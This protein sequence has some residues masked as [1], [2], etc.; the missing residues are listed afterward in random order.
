M[1]FGTRHFLL[2]VFFFFIVPNMFGQDE[3]KSIE[4][5][6]IMVAIEAQH[7]VKFSYAENDVVGHSIFPP[8][9]KLP[10]KAKLVYLTNRTL[11]Y[12]KENE[13]Y[14]S[15]YTTLIKPKDR[16][17]CAYV[18]DEVGQPIDNA[19]IQYNGDRRL[20]TASDGF[21]EL[22][23]G[24]KD[25]VYVTHMGYEAI[26]VKPNYTPDDDCLEIILK[27]S[28]VQLQEVVTERYIATGI[29]KQ[30]DGTYAIKP[31]K[32]GI[33]PGLIEPDVLQ[34]MQQLPG[35]NSIDETV[36]NINVRGGTHDQN[37]FMWNG[38]RLF[39]TG[40][41]FGLISALSP[42]LAHDIKISKNGTSAFYGESVSSA[43]DISSRPKDIGT[44]STSIGT[45]M[46]SADFYTKIKAS[47]KANFEV[48]ARRSFTD[49]L[50]FPTYSK[51]SKRIFQNTIVT[52]LS[53]ST[54]VNYKSDKEF[55]F[56]DFTTQYHQKI[57]TKHDL[58]ADVIGISNTLDF[59]QGT[60]TATNVVT[61]ISTLNQLTLGGTVAWRTQWS[62]GHSSEASLYASYYNVDG[63]NASIEN[64]QTIEQQNRILDAG[65][66]FS[67]NLKLSPK[68]TLH[69]GYQY[70]E[71]G[72]ENND[73]V[74]QPDYS[75]NVKEV[76]RSH[77]V[78]GE[79]EYSP[80]ESRLYARGGLRI[81]YIE[82]FA[83]LYA[84]PRLLVNYQLNNSFKLEAL[85][86]R[87]SQTASQIVALQADFLGIEKRRWVLANDNDL[88]VQKSSQAS[89]G[90][91]FKSRRWLVTL[92]NFYKKVDGI[93]TFGQAFQD[94]LELTQAKGNYTV[95]G[96]EF[97]I[98]KQFHDFY[99]WLSYTW[100]NN[101]YR[102]DGVEPYK[103]PS[104]FE[105]SH[106]VNTAVIYEWDNLK[107][108]L[109]SK[110]FTGRPYTPPLI[111]TPTYNNVGTASI[112]YPYPNS[113]NIN[114]FFQV[115]FSASYTWQ[116]PR[117]ISMQVGVAVQNIF[118]R[119]NIINRYYRINNTNDGVEVVNTY[120]LERTP[121]ALIKFSF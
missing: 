51:Y 87:K 93:T 72:T 23:A 15:V 39:Q 76:L 21:F 34:A 48:S 60:I 2:T 80:A 38:I 101:N 41:F 71:I 111:N 49:V 64:N 99:A 19:V 121:N 6:K 120:S 100:N 26:I 3:L 79:M 63:K 117:K 28:P 90:A 58:Y 56:Y 108:A 78:I 94:Q 115:N 37:L 18:V 5:K 82:Q 91:T 65:L 97:L 61:Q 13:R 118:N 55:Y 16:H 84:E 110:W 50:D 9:P 17:G 86:E 59:T 29:S 54:D 114:N 8:D 68:F 1:T 92:D 36:S 57:G 85:A 75:R 32:F 88:P 102:F 20:V 83:M 107:M 46:I 95:Y 35:I 25:D 24:F 70:N 53:N 112:V 22:P 31:R 77:A 106:T 66:R 44:G 40:H 30:K 119:Q 73:R 42:N 11:L 105:L 12:F 43:V 89:V 81:N 96:T 4:L 45:N 33:L 7:N 104:S 67:D 103:F 69:S 74:N 109:G 27:L 47:E 98:Q 10:L 52:S 113:E 62:K 116:L 14:I